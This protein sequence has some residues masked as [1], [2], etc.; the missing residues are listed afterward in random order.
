V[1]TKELIKSEIDNV[2]DEYLGALY[3]IVKALEE[4]GRPGVSERR[5]H[6]A[7]WVQF[8]AETYGSL[9]NAPIER[10]DQGEYEVRA[11]FA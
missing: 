9:A 4:P 6:E 10:G 11:S 5:G 2:R 1:I 7:S 3:R 8:V